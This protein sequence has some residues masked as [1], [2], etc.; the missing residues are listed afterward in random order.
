M[1]WRLAVNTEGYKRILLAKEKELSTQIGGA[2]D[3]ALDQTD[4]SEVQ[5]RGDASVA[6]EAKEEQFAVADM[7]WALLKEVREALQRLEDGSFG[8]CTVDGGPIEEKR[9]K[10]VPWARYCLKHQVELER[11]QPPQI[12]TL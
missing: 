5:D 3:E 1:A 8:T 12:A 9:L 4:V 10:Q 11:S 6:D 2:R 7:D